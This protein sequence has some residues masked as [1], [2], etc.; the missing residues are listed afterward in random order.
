MGLNCL[1]KFFLNCSPK[2]YLSRAVWILKLPHTNLVQA[3]LQCTFMIKEKG[4][5]W[6]NCGYIFCV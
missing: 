4:V 3:I 2:T 6:N 1:N 5:F